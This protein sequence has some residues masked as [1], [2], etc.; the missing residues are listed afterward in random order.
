MAQTTIRPNRVRYIKLGRHGGWEQECLERQ[1]IRIG[2]GSANP[3]KFALCESGQWQEIATRYV[4]EGRDKGTANR[5]AAELRLFCEDD[6]ST[7]WLTFA[8]ERLYWAFLTRTGPER[9]A[10][11]KGVWRSVAGCWRWT[12]V[13]GEPLT[14]QRLSGAITKLAAFRGT[15]CSVDHAEYIVRRI[16]GQKTPEVEQALASLE[17]MKASALGL[18]RL[19]EPRDFEL[20]VDLIFSTSGWRRVGVVGGTQKTLDIDLVLPSTGERAFVQVK[21]HTDSAELAEY[22]A[23]IDDEHQRMFYV[24][25][26]GKA[27]TDDERV[28]V[29]GP[30]QVAE[31]VIDAGLVGWLIRKVS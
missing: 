28:T 1:I 18:I 6:G 15:S 10:D 12:D 27:T 9:H 19:L 29:V 26:S 30:E 23:Q 7:L 5:F 16:N 3:E 31:L 17:Q 14:K 4:A 13:N 25:H 21:S 22:V 2:F 11:G 24:H 8:R 20:L